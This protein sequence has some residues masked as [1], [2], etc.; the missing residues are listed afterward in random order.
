MSIPLRLRRAG[1]LFTLGSGPLTRGSDR[2]EFAWR[3]LLTL[4]LL[5][6]APLGVIAGRAVAAGLD[7]TAQHQAHTRTQERATLLRDAAARPS[8]GG[9]GVSTS[10]TWPGPDGRAHVGTVAA[11]PGARA[12]SPVDIWVDRSGRPAE[13]PMSHDAV[14]DQALVAGAV[15]FFGVVIAGLSLHLIVLGLLARQ[16]NRRWEAGWQ[17]VE[18]LWVSRFG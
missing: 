9:L 8:A 18:P 13:P 14:V 16:R 5:L 11:P 17:A 15:T 12:G 6:A 1:R 4:T 3:I 2:L 10:A 7:A